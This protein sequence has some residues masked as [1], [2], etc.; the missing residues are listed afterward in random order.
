MTGRHESVGESSRASMANRFIVDRSGS[1]LESQ[2][3]TQRIISA[4]VQPPFAISRDRRQPF[5]MQYIETNGESF[6]GK[7][8]REG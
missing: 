5:S 7:N 2:A 6:R 8:K 3:I 1:H 4:R